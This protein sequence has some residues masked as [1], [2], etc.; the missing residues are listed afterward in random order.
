MTIYSDGNS[1]KGYKYSRH[2]IFHPKYLYIS[3][4]YEMRIICDRIID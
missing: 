3:N 2:I 1:S 4:A